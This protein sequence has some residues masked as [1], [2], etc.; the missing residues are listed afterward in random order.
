MR[1][2]IAR[3]FVSCSPAS[4]NTGTSISPSRSHS[5]SCV[6]VPVARRLAAKAAGG[7]AEPVVAHRCLLREPGEE[8]S[9][10]AIRR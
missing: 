1:S 6:P 4:T 3:N 9:W 8:G 7:V 10:R 5:G 2:P